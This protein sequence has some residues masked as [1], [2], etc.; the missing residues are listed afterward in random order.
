MIET[1]KKCRQSSRHARSG[2]EACG[3]IK[4]KRMPMLYVFNS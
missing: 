3:K 1:R 2:R 4:M